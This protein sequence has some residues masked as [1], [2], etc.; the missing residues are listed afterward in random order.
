VVSAS[1]VVKSKTVQKKSISGPS[2][3]FPL[4]PLREVPSPPPLSLLVAD[5]LT[6]KRWGKHIPPSFLLSGNGASPTSPK[7]VKT[8][9][10]SSKLDP[11]RN[12][13]C[14]RPFRTLRSVLS[15]FRKSA[16]NPI[17]TGICTLARFDTP[18]PGL[19]G[20][21]ADIPFFLR[22]PLSA[23]VFRP[24]RNPHSP[25]PIKMSRLGEGLSRPMSRLKT[26]NH[27]VNIGLA[28]CHGSNASTWVPPLQNGHCRSRS[29]PLPIAHSNANGPP[30]SV[31]VT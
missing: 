5:G 21:G 6:A 30:R 22:F 8:R 24:L 16:E 4:R 13:C 19:R 29:P 7:L 26:Q 15:T 31:W 1:S 18:F 17:M 12:S 11:G 14:C 23:F 20:G 2:S 28:R 10:N 9:Q 25:L 27:P 3:S